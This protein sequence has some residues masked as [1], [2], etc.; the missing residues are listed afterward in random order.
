MQRYDASPCRTRAQW[1]VPYRQESCENPM[2]ATANRQALRCS[3]DQRRK[4]VSVQCTRRFSPTRQRPRQRLRRRRLRLLQQQQQQLQQ[5]RQLQRQQAAPAARER[6][7]GSAVRSTAT[8]RMRA[9]SPSFRS[10]SYRYHHFVVCVV[11]VII[12]VIIA[13]AAASSSLAVAA[14]AAAVVAKPATSASAGPHRF[15]GW[16]RFTLSRPLQR[17]VCRSPAP[18][19]D[20]NYAPSF[21]RWPPGE[22]TRPSAPTSDGC[23]EAT[24]VASNELDTVDGG[25]ARRPLDD[26]VN[27]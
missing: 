12:T 16:P 10:F 4:V 15:A 25:D 27:L 19:S 1:R 23:I 17:V 8:R 18:S 14:A 26:N 9:W 2:P 24:T 6:H 20:A 5:L 3:D 7:C 11:T 22:N 13:C 21:D